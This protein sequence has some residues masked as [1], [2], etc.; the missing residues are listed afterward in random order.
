MAVLQM[1]FSAR[2]TDAKGQSRPCRAYY[3]AQDNLTLANLIVLLEG[4]AA[5]IGAL[6][7][8]GIERLS[9]TISDVGFSTPATPGGAAIE[10]TG[11]LNFN[12]TGPVARRWAL[13]IPAFSNARIIGDRINLTDVDTE[14]VIAEFTNTNYT[15]DHYQQITSLADAFLSFHRDRKQLQRSSFETP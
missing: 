14:V 3:N 9:V 6:T 13:A 7:D 4:F 11:M 12:A 8:A 5:D 2:L 10:Q 15:N 1:I